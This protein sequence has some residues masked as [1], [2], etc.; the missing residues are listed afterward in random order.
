[1]LAWFCTGGQWLKT[2]FVLSLMVG[3]IK[4]LSLAGFE[5]RRERPVATYSGKPFSEPLQEKG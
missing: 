3:K 4:Y 1:M 5:A 2:F